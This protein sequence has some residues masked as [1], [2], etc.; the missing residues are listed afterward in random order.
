MLYTPLMELEHNICY[1]AL[2][3]RDARFDGRFFTA[4]SS[5]GI[6]CR[7]VCPASTPKLENCTFYPTASAALNAGFRPCLR[8]RPESAPASPAWLGTEATV[9]RAMRLIEEGALDDG[10][11][12]A[13]L[14]DRLGVGE[15]HLRRLF[16]TYLGASPK[17]IAQTRRLMFAK[18]LLKQ[19]EAP[20]IEIAHASG[21]NSLRRF[22]DAY[23][24]SFGFAP[25]HERKEIDA[26][27]HV[28][29]AITLRFTYRPPYDW[30]GLLD[31]FEMRAIDPAEWV[32]DGRYH[33]RIMIDGQVGEISVQHEADKNRLCC[34]IRAIPT[35][36]LQTVS[37]RIRRMFDV[38]ADPQ[39]IAY[40]LKAD[41]ALEPLIDD[42]PGLRL[43]GA[44]DGFEIAVRAV[45]GQQISVKGARTICTRLVAR[46][47]TGLFPSPQDILDMNMDGLGLTGRRIA[48]LKSLAQSWSGLDKAK[49]IEDTLKELCALP[50]IGPW[51][52]HY[53]VMRS[54]GEP[55]VY[56]VDDLG[57]IRGLEK[58]GLPATKEDLKARAENWRPWRA[59]GA[60]YL[61]RVY[62]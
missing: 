53:I 17:Q 30:D 14:C 5:T 2:K 60:M 36:H 57:L 28:C 32:A 20:V 46:V 11:S 35:A 50:G 18:R 22:N 4:V 26:N 7:P 56:P 42:Y 8:C 62:A 37:R 15:R 48:T 55:D 59:Y 33:R 58:L 51:T 9:R 45:I 39:A 38:D 13:T 3:T 49:P 29:D 6:F 10:Q 27:P 43:P 61:W 54:F 21:F 34:H 44:W 31:F 47:G 16:Q 40:D 52:A 1:Q 25:S 19:T 41:P 23:K 12:V 24:K